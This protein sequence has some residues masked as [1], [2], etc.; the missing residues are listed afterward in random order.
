MSSVRHGKLPGPEDRDRNNPMA[1]VV[2]GVSFGGRACLQTQ[3][4]GQ[5]QQGAGPG[6]WGV[7]RLWVGEEHW[8]TLPPFRRARALRGSRGQGLGPQGE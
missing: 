8:S 5:K 4:G 2:G 3:G 7:R 6:L 1:A